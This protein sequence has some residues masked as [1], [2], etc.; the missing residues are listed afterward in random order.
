VDV[1]EAVISADS[2]FDFLSDDFATIS[3]PGRL[4]TPAGK[5]EPFTVQ[6]LNA[7]V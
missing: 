2:A 3:L 5:T 6:L 1:F 7:A 4:K